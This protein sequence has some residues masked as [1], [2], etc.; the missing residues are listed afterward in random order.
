[1]SHM[2]LDYDGHSSFNASTVMMQH[3]SFKCRNVAEQARYVNHNSL[4]TLRPKKGDHDFAWRSHA[5]NF[6]RGGVH[7]AGKNYFRDP[8][9]GVW[10]SSQK[11]DQPGCSRQKPDACH[12]MNNDF[13]R[14]GFGSQGPGTGMSFRSTFGGPF[15]RTGSE[16]NLR[17]H[18]SS[19]L[20]HRHARR[21]DV[22]RGACVTLR[23]P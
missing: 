14:P 18:D 21:P 19:E 16:P 4:H 5:T 23:S 13:D 11:V 3:N 17:P 10:F 7:Y 22:L 15:R 9:S 1:M 20:Q 2:V 8:R 12:Y 6:A